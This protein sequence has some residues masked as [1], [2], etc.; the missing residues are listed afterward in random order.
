MFDHLDDPRPPRSGTEQQI[1][2]ARRGGRALL[3]SR[4]QHR[5]AVGSA[6]LAATAGIAAVSAVG[7]PGAGAGAAGPTAT[8]GTPD[9]VTPSIARTTTP[10][11]TQAEPSSAAPTSAVASPAASLPPT[12]AAPVLTTAPPMAAACSHEAA[13]LRTSV[14]PAGYA[15]TDPGDGVIAWTNA[16]GPLTTLV[17]SVLCA[18]FSAADVPPGDGPVKDVAVL[19]AHHWLIGSASSG[20]LKEVWNADNGTA[21]VINATVQPSADETAAEHQLSMFGNYLID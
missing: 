2:A 6:A 21:V 1:G 17:V 18:P 13:R 7:L 9:V 11:T 8:N 20:R 12:T 15:S 10:P 19:D 3:H 16:G 14:E 4:R 5:L